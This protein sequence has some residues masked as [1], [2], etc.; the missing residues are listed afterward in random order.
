MPRARSLDAVRADV[1]LLD[2]P[3][4]RL[5]VADEDPVLEP[6]AEERPASSSE[7]FE[8]EVDDVVRIARAVRVARRRRRSR[9]TA[10]RRPLG[11][12]RVRERARNG[13]TSATLEPTHHAAA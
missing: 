2:H 6:V 7:S 13:W 1:V 10:A 5:V 11:R 4:G 12:A 8:R 9:R 3:G